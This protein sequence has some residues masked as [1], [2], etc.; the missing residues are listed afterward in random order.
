MSIQ[1]VTKKAGEKAIHEG[2]DQVV[3]KV[4]KGVYGYTSSTDSKG[5]KS[6]KIVC[7]VRLFYKN[8]VLEPRVCKA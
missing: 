2:Y 7:Y 5:M 6:K 8:K 1:E 4:R 3:F